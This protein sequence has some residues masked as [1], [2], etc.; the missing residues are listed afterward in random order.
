LDFTLYPS[1][2]GYTIVSRDITEHRR[3]EETLRLSEAKYHTLIDAMDQG[4][5]FADVIFDDDGRPADVFYREANPAAVKMVNAC[6]HRWAFGRLRYLHRV[7]AQAIPPDVQ[8]RLMDSYRAV[9]ARAIPEAADDARFHRALVV[10]SFARLAALCEEL[11]TAWHADRK[12]GRST[13]RQRIVAA[14]EHFL[15]LAAEYA[16]FPA[17]GGAVA[18][19]HERLLR[20]WPAESRILPV[21]P[22]FAARDA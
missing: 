5:I 15:L 17:L 2:D 11:P 18:A 14:V 8:S 4:V 16:V 19:L 20:Q 1:S 6:A 13:S 9:L 22:A 7:W 3:A 12:W 21:F 10:C